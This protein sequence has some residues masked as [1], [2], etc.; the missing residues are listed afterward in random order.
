MSTDQ[1]WRSRNQRP[2]NEKTAM[3]RALRQ[4]PTPA[5]RSAWGI[6]RRK[7][8][9]GLRFRRQHVI[10]GYIVDFYCPRLRLAIEIDGDVHESLAQ[11]QADA[12]RKAHLQR[13]GVHIVRLWNHEVSEQNLTQKV[14]DFMQRSTQSPHLC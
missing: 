6:L 4:S 10:E 12:E 3:A 14:T 2:T 5:E 8:I 7:N 13:L 9:H 11:R 1:K